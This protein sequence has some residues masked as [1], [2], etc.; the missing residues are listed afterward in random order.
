[1]DRC[2]CRDC[3]TDIPKCPHHLD[4]GKER[5]WCYPRDGK[6]WTPETMRAGFQAGPSGRDWI[7]LHRVRTFTS[8]GSPAIEEGGEITI[9]VGAITYFGEMQD[10]PEHTRLI[11]EGVGLDIWESPDTVIP[12]RRAFIAIGMK[13]EDMDAGM[14][15]GLALDDIREYLRRR[16]K[17]ADEELLRKEKEGLR[18]V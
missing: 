2:E 11:A 15:D 3:G 18:G 6:C 7:V 14:M 16:M 17:A 12:A 5:R 13:K 1:M 8:N 4:W 9:R 10:W